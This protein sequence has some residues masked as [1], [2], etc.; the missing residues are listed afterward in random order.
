MVS[1]VYFFILI[2]I[3]QLI[4]VNLNPLQFLETLFPGYEYPLVFR[5]SKVV[6]IVL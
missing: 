2:V 1:H 6:R 3:F 5:L 4:I